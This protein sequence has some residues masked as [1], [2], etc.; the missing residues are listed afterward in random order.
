MIADCLQLFWEEPTACQ[1]FADD[2][3]ACPDEGLAWIPVLSPSEAHQWQL[4]PSLY[5]ANLSDT[6]EVAF[7]PLGPTGV[8][9]YNS[10]VRDVLEAFSTP[11]PLCAPSPSGADAASADKILRQLTRLAILVPADSPAPLRHVQPRTLHAWLHV[12]NACNLDCAYCYVSRNGESM[13]EA[14]GRAAMEAVFRSA[15][16]NGF[17]SIKIK[18]AGGEPTLRFPLVEELHQVVVRLSAQYGLEVQEIVLSNGIGLTEAIIGMLQESGIALMISLDGVG[19][20][21]DAHRRFSDGRGSCDLVRQGI[22]RA[23]ARGLVPQLMITVSRYNADRLA[24]VTAFALDYDLP[25]RLNFYRETDRIPCP[26][27]LTPDPKALVAGVRAAFSVI[28]SRLPRRRLIGGLL[29]RSLFA[30]PHEHSCAAGHSYLVIDP[31]GRVARCQMTLDEPVTDVW[32]DDPLQAIRE[33]RGGFQNVP[34]DE[35]DGCC[36]CTWRYWCAG[37]CPLLTYRAAGRSDV[38]SPYCAVYKALYPDLLRL[39]GLRLLKWRL[40]D[41]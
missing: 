33:R 11:R 41:G 34:V 6:H 22:E 3:C 5:R 4:A 31:R 24:E 32:A 14:T 23:L 30:Y 13:D 9:V 19:P 20:A 2:D 28:E 29:D 8:V 17:Q 25:F 18:Y 1:V 7:N 37:G 38:P 35:R 16:R 39:E 27:S 15:S 36:D 21:H 40:P 26:A 10:P 12:T